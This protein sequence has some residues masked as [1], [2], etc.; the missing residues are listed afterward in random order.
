MKVRQALPG[1]SIR[2]RTGVRWRGRAPRLLAASAMT[3]ASVLATVLVAGSP[4]QAETCLPLDT[5]GETSVGI[6]TVEHCNTFETTTTHWS[7]VAL[8]SEPWDSSYVD[9]DLTVTDSAG[10]KLA[11]SRLGGTTIDF[12]AIDS[13]RRPLGTYVARGKLY[14]G[15]GYYDLRFDKGGESLVSLPVYQMNKMVQV[16]DL[17]VSAGQ[18][19]AVKAWNFAYNTGAMH[20]MASDPAQ[21]ASYVQPKASAVATTTFSPADVNNADGGSKTLRFTAS[22]SAWYG[23]VI[24]NKYSG[25]LEGMSEALPRYQRVAC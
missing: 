6:G 4:A 9:Y 14:G 17:W 19:V 21:P 12:V 8:K 3:A 10:T 20:V 18:C 16:K 11:E 22:R 2:A 7:A 1:T 25:R 15:H 24:T 23:F 13:H 5:R